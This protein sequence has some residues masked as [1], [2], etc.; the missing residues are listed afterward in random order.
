MSPLQK[1]LS[2]ATIT[3]LASAG[4][5][6]AQQVVLLQSQVESLQQ[7]T[8][9]LAHVQKLQSERDNATMQL[10][11]LTYEL[12]D[13]QR[14]RVELS[15]LREELRSLHQQTN[16]LGRLVQTLATHRD[17]VVVAELSNHSDGAAQK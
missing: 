13:A 6:A 8:P 7:Q 17:A 11:A 16:R 14:D 9:L 3:I 10:T 4:I 5:Y 15:V 2:T 1:A 12:A